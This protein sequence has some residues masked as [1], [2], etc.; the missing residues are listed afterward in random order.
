[1]IICTPWSWSCPCPCETV[2]PLRNRCKERIRFPR[3]LLRGMPAKDKLEGSRSR[4]G[5][6]SG[7]NV[8]LMPM[9]EERKGRMSRKSLRSQCSS[10]KAFTKLIENS[11]ED[12]HWKSTTSGRN[13]PALDSHHAQSL[14]GSSL[15]EIRYWYDTMV[16]PKVQQLEPISQL[17]PT[18]P[19]GSL[20]GL[21]CIPYGCY[22]LM[23]RKGM[24][25]ME[26]E[27]LGR[28][29][30]KAI[31]VTLDFSTRERIL[32]FLCSS[33]LSSLNLYVL[34]Q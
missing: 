28:K 13:V 27:V 5:E 19:A 33:V 18:T 6:A 17:C 14:A 3:G 30:I 16:D 26:K 1:M 12:C 2:P 22:N 34:T 15:E 23:V 20:E 25:G 29:R 21:N 24:G 31:A 32:H 7:Y 4:Q 11:Q 10:K 8:G 9:K